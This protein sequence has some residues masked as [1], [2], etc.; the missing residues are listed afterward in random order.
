MNALYQTWTNGIYPKFYQHENM[1]TEDIEYDL[2]AMEEYLSR[3]LRNY[4][5]PR[6][7]N[8][9]LAKISKL[10]PKVKLMF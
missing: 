5:L 1:G 9:T 7:S 3:N 10:S 6:A 2:P 4:S 8:A